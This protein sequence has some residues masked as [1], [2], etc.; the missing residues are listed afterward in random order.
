VV[1]EI[2]VKYPGGPTRITVAD[3][4]STPPGTRIVQLGELT[5]KKSRVGPRGFWIQK[6]NGRCRYRQVAV[7]EVKRQ[8]QK[9]IAL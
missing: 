2:C 7:S 6:Q 3:L 9:F 5:S 8:L 4:A 1:I